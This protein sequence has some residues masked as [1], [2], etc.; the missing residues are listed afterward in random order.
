M[1]ESE[2]GFWEREWR[3]R[4]IETKRKIDDLLEKESGHPTRM[5]IAAQVFFEQMNLIPISAFRIF[6]FD[7]FVKVMKDRLLKEL[8][9][10]EKSIKPHKLEESEATEATSPC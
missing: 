4:E 3:P 1:K 5:N 10:S 8:E 7:E 2:K 6:V 9:E